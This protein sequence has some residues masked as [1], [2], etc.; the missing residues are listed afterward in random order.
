MSVYF[1]LFRALFGLTKIENALEQSAS[2]NIEKVGPI[3]FLPNKQTSKL[4]MI[5]N[6]KVGGLAGSTC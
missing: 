5:R 4:I 2:N 1:Y 3:T 6:W